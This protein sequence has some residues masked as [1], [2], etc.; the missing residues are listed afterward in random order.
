MVGMIREMPSGHGF[1]DIV[2]LPLPSSGKP[3]LVVEL[4]YEQ[5]ADAA[6]RQIKERHYTQA[7]EGYT[8]DILLIGVN[9]SKDDRGK[10]HS[11]VIERLRP[12][13]QT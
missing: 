6:I 7:L 11:C 9:Y 4:K 5:S 2:F 1:A 3:A 8:G 12:E 13:M 10:T